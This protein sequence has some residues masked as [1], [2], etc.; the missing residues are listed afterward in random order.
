MNEEYC[1]LMGN[2]TWNQ[3]VPLPK[4]IKLVKY[5]WVY[6]TKYASFGSVQIHKARLVSKGISQVEGIDYIETFT[7]IAK[8]N[9]ICLV[10]AI[11]A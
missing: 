7:L 4:R 1:S 9:S 2:D 10:L 5:K 11:V 8:M 3:L 6:R